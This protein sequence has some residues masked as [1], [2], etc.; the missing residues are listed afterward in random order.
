MTELLTGYG[1]ICEVWFDGACGEGPN[2]KK[3]NYDTYRWYSLIRRL[4]PS[5]VIAVMGPDVRWVGTENG[6]GRETEWSVIPNPNIDNLKTAQGVS[7][8]GDDPILMPNR[9]IRDADLGSRNAIADAK[10]LVW[11]P[12]ETD[13]SIRPSW[14]YTD[15]D[16]GL[17]KSAETL[18]NIYFTSVGRN[19][20]LLLNIPPN[21]EGLFGKDEVESLRQFSRLREQ[22]FSVNHLQS[23]RI[24]LEGDKWDNPSSD[25]A[26]R[27]ERCCRLSQECCRRRSGLSA[28]S[29]LSRRTVG[30]LYDTDY[31]TSVVLSRNGLSFTFDEPLTISILSIQEDIRAGQRVESFVLEYLDGNG[32]WQI[33]TSGTTIGYK[34]LLRFDPVTASRFRI[35]FC[36]VRD[37][38]VISQIGLY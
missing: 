37:V 27:S 8:A 10:S 13:V 25:R 16:N 12:A 18:M 20:N 38:P 5:A 29:G 1:P 2:G 32:V 15:A 28:R 3:Q 4:Q 36:S 24:R 7:T 35:R 11:Y 19:G 34:R 21:R 30:W 14:F 9:D 17:T 23:A 6:I 33:A 22:L 31:E 26:F